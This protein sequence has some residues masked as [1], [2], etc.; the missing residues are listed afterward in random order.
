MEARLLKCADET[1]Q[2]EQEWVLHDDPRSLSIC[3]KF[4]PGK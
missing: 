4:V 3:D 2:D 1:A